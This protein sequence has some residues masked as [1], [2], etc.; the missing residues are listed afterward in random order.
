MKL[1]RREVSRV[2]TPGT[3]TDTNILSPGENNFL[4][5]LNEQDG[6]LGCSF[7]DISTGEFR[8]S[9]FS[10]DDRWDRLLLDV[11]HLGP[12]EVLFPERMKE[13]AGILHDISKTPLDDWLF[14]N[15]YASR[16]LR[17]QLGASTLD[18]FS[19]GGKAAAVGAAGAMI[20][21]VKQTQKTTLEHITGLTFHEAA[22]YLVLDPST[23]R[24]LELVESADGDS[25]DT[26]LGVINRTRTGMG[27]RLLRNWL[28]R[29]SIDAAEI[30]TR[31]DAVAELVPSPMQLEAVRSS[32]EGIFD[33]ERL[34][35]KI[36]IG[37]SSPRELTALRSS[38]GRLPVV[39]KV[40]SELKARNSRNCARSST[41]SRTFT[42]SC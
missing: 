9:Q 36:T 8:V 21:Y 32:F 33:L 27:A 37:T 1:V 22:N 29:P 40:L 28:V 19:L 41:S 26:L 5:S 3:I 35:G 23:I 20:H 30:E 12:R 24:N 42:S 10:G 34:L 6:Q 18:G 38:I 17:D 16:T 15:D 14:D 25:K 39:D 4:L 7:L 31:L 11:E 2:I 13:A